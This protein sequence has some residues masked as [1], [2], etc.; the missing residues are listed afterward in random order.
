ML[1][2]RPGPGIELREKGVSHR[3]KPRK[4][5]FSPY[6]RKNADVA[7]VRDDEPD[8]FEL[9]LETD[10]GDDK[11]GEDKDGDD[12]DANKV[13][14]REDDVLCSSS[15]REGIDAKRLVPPMIAGGFV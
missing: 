7:M 9:E 15:L 2:K 8:E 3:G 13:S 1:P 5:P 4:K 6:R 11:D 12:G 10:N 14:D